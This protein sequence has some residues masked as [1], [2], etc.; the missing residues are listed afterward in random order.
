MDTFD[1]EFRYMKMLAAAWIIILIG[2][3][4][5]GIWVI[6]KIMQHFKVV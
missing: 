4:V 1:K 5:F 3:A 6:L 2:G